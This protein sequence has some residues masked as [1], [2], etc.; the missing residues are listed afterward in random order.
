MLHEIVHSTVSISATFAPCGVPGV[1]EGA[2]SVGGPPSNTCQRNESIAPQF[3]GGPVTESSLSL[4]DKALFPGGHLVPPSHPQ[5]DFSFS[6]GASFFPF[7]NMP[8]FCTASPESLQTLRKSD[9]RSKRR[10]T[11]SRGPTRA[12]PQCPLTC[13]STRHTVGSGDPHQAG[14]LAVGQ[15][16]VGAASLS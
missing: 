4:L 14:G 15:S 10:L 5:Q 12:S 3:P 2:P 1:W 9:R 16:R 7:Q 8:S 6:L 11:G 13:G